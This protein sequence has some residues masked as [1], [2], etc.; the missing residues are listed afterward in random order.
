[1]NEKRYYVDTSY[2]NKGNPVCLVMGRNDAYSAAE[3]LCLC[4]HEWRAEEE[5][6]DL[7]SIAHANGEEVI[8]NPKYCDRYYKPIVRSWW[9][10]GFIMLI[11]LP[12]TWSVSGI[13]EIEAETIEE[14][15]NSFDATSDD[16]PLPK[17]DY[18]QT[19]FE[20]ISYDEEFI[21]QYQK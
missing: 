7:I 17:G 8:Y 6:K 13:V 9:K 4:N 11:K 3:I 15:I 20:L 14:A 19:S 18:V 5:V 10:A 1:M 21:A 16:I 12:V 2:D